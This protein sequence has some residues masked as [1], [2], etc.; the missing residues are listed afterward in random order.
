MNVAAATTI[1]AIKAPIQE[2]NTASM[3]ILIIARPQLTPRPQLSRKLT[4]VKDLGATLAFFCTVARVT[5]R[6]SS[7]P[8]ACPSGLADERR[9]SHYDLCNKS[10]HTRKQHRVYDDSDHCAPP[11]DSPTAA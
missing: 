1:S 11:V 5:W 10:A 7:S 6:V 8:F 4:S 9:C 3:M 2:N